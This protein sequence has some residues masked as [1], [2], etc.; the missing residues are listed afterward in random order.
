MGIGVEVEVSVCLLPGL[1]V[2][3]RIMVRGFQRLGTS[4]S[5]CMTLVGFPV[6]SLMPAHHL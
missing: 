6:S 1:E 4:H 3:V 2:R 5:Q